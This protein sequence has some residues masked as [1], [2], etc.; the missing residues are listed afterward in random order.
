MEYIKSRAELAAPNTD[1]ESS[2]KRARLKGLGAEA[3]SFFWKLLH[4]LLPTEERLSRIL[5]N[6]S[7]QC[8][9]CPGPVIADL[10]HCL[11][12]CVHTKDVGNWLLSLVRHHD[13]T[14]SPAKLIKLMFAAEVSAEMPLVW[15]I[16]QTLLYVWGIRASGKTAT[17]VLTRAMLES[18]I[19]LLRETRFRN[20]QNLMNEY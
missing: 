10:T 13:N 16:A 11:L 3:S 5:P 4:N 9:Y 6:S 20:E 1:W 19:S 15:I 17:L 14:V 8:K 2:W 12:Q 18:K 7:A